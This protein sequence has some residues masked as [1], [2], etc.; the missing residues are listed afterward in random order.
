MGKHF[1]VM[2]CTKKKTLGC[3][4]PSEL[5]PLTMPIMLSFI[6]DV[7]RFNTGSYLV[8]PTILPGIMRTRLSLTEKKAA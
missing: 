4:A 5:S 2:L 8:T 1:K 3:V 6:T 7:F